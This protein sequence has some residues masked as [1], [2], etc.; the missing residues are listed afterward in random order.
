MDSLGGPETKK[1]RWS[2]NSFTNSPG[3]NGATRDLF[4]NYGYGSHAAINQQQ[5][6][7][8]NG[9]GMNGASGL[10]LGTNQLYSTPSLSV[11]TAANGLGMGSQISPSSAT[12]PY[13]AMQQQQQ[14]GQ[15]GQN[16]TGYNFGNYGMNGMN[17][18][19]GMGMSGMGMLGGF[20]YSP[21]LGSFQQVRI[22]LSL[23]LCSLL[24]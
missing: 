17:G 15:P 8:S 22:Y 19:L 1:A 13:S 5:N 21:Q 16:G 18:M 6:G 20:P 23:I 2:P 24:I 9:L 12:S 14:N 4:A 11:N 3:T 10:G 7:F